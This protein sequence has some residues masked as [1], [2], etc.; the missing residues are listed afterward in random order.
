MRRAI[1]MVVSVLLLTAAS[2]QQPDLTPVL[3]RYHLGT[4][5]TSAELST[6]AAAASDG[7]LL[8]SLRTDGW[9]WLQAGGPAGIA[10][11]RLSMA[12]LVLE[13]ESM[14]YQTGVVSS[15]VIEWACANLRETEKPLPAERAWQIA[16]VA[17]MQR[18]A[19]ESD[20]SVHLAH[21]RMRF[22]NEPRLL[23]A[24]AWKHRSW[25]PDGFRHNPLVWTNPYVPYGAWGHGDGSR[26]P[27][28]VWSPAGTIAEYSA[29]GFSGRE[30]NQYWESTQPAGNMGSPVLPPS[31]DED[32]FFRAE[33][34]YRRARG[35]AA[36]AAEAELRLGELD[37]LYAKPTSAFD[38]FE[39]ALKRTSDPDLRYLAYFLMGRS[40]EQQSQ[41]SAA[42]VYYNKALQANPNGRSVI[43]LWARVLDQQGLFAE[44]LAMRARVTVPAAADPWDAFS[45][46][47][48]VSVP[49][50]IVE[51]RKAI[52]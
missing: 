22:E 35:A 43:D 28:L 9:D 42:C 5:P 52:Q 40:E 6:L 14:Q 8:T 34:D 16:T 39:A 33:N 23:L 48:L 4:V 31:T 38:H 26:I 47:D 49:S 21:A 19:S 27:M 3:E 44:A 45:T 17:L 2:R 7:R 29:P 46:G 18:G 24:D 11:R 37:L 51:L 25:I 30:N 20:Y 32:H 41:W 10:G 36:V 50:L 1:G 15:P 12:A 13:V